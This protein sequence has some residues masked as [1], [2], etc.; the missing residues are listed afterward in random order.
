[1]LPGGF[2]L[3]GMDSIKDSRSSAVHFGLIC[4]SEISVY[5]IDGSLQL[6]Y[7]FVRVLC[8]VGRYFL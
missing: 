1:M 2:L 4:R 6:L 7:R 3:Q 5:G 8:Q